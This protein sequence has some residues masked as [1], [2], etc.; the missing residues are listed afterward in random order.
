MSQVET[1]RV[2]LVAPSLEIT[3]GQSRQ[4]ARLLAAF[5]HERTLA[6][7]FIPHNPRLP[8]PWRKLQRLKFVRTVVTTSYYWWL[9]LTQLWRY[10]IVHIF[11]A[12][13][14]SYLLAVAPAILIGK[15]YGK[16]VIL[17]YRSGEAEDHLQHWPLT[18]KPIMRLADRIVAPS[19]YLVDVFARFG[20][21]AESIFNIV[22]L[23]RFRFRARAPLQPKFLCCRL[24]EPLYNVG[25]V[26]RAFQQIQQRYPN[27]S[28]TIA[29]DGSQRA[30]LEQL[31]RTLAVRQVAFRGIVPFEQMPQL[32][33]EHDVCLIG[34]DIDNMPATILEACASGL[35]V[36]STEAGGIPYLVK[37]EVSALLVPCGDHAG[38]AREAMRLLEDA[39]LAQQLRQ[40]AHALVQ[41]CTW[42]SVRG[43]WLKLYMDLMQAQ[44]APRRASRAT[45]PQRS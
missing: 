25:L 13:Y 42:E 17:N 41:Q 9:L 23:D 29:G 44:N 15:L 2:C 11:S 38:L 7:G 1:I 43:Q 27:A 4:A 21:Q 24:L 30:A 10:D 12:S 35:P 6:L 36:V 31:A 22:E 20:L 26:L 14:F 40:Q 39:T 34:N 19:S 3:G 33:D 8:A 32:Y 16:R 37:H 28:L 5:Q 45:L 18:T